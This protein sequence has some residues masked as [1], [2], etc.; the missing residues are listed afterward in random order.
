MPRTIPV[1]APGFKVASIA[2]SRLL[3]GARPVA[4]MSGLLHGIVLPVVVCDCGK[5]SRAVQLEHRI[6][7]DAGKNR[8]WKVQW[9]EG[10]HVWE[11][12]R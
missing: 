4:R 9:P 5:P 10:G 8:L 6:S 2:D 11:R 3:V 1:Y 12:C 7:Q